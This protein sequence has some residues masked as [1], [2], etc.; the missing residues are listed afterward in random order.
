MNNLSRISACF[1]LF[2]V[3]LFI[4]SCTTGPTKSQ[5]VKS[6]VLNEMIMNYQWERKADYGPAVYNF[7]FY[8]NGK[9]EGV[10][11]GSQISPWRT[12]HIDGS[13]LVLDEGKSGRYKYNK[14]T[15]S[16]Y[17][18]DPKNGKGYIFR[19]KNDNYEEVKLK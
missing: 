6:N 18:R 9:C 12:W 15:R 19:I 17:G 14:S 5:N 13:Y 11:G 4:S 1:V 8:P 10:F 2:T 7:K 3:L 16:F